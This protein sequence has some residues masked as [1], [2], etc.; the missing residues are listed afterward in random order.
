MQTAETIKFRVSPKTF[1]KALD[2]ELVKLP[3][4]FLWEVG[5]EFLIINHANNE[6]IKRKLS[7]V[8]G[9]YGYFK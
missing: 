6:S 7:A 2:R 5:E 4:E 9:D 1:Y 8:I 3:E